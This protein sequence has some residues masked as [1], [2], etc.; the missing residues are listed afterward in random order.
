MAILFT[1]AITGLL[2][3]LLLLGHYED[4]W[5]M[6]PIGLLTVGLIVGLCLVIFQPL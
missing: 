6:V 4:N 5:Q 2:A 3:E 1:C